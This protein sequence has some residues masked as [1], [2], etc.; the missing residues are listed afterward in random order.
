M[1]GSHSAA[2]VASGMTTIAAGVG[3]SHHVGS[4]EV[5]T[6]RGKPVE[7]VAASGS[8]LI[9]GKLANLPAWVREM[10]NDGR[11]VLTDRRFIHLSEIGQREGGP[12]D[13]LV[14]WPDGRIEIFDDRAFCVR[15]GPILESGFDEPAPGSPNDTRDSANC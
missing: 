7:V 9:Q 14:K 8:E 11:L 10:S 2:V 4:R 15:F 3:S 5:P 1:L 6:H 13:W 12:L